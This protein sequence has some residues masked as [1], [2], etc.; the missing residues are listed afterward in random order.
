MA[1]TTDRKFVLVDVK[2][3]LVEQTVHCSREASVPRKGVTGA[4]RAAAAGTQRL[5]TELKWQNDRDTPFV[6]RG[7]SAGSARGRNASI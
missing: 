7:G 1:L 3:T 2:V 5:P 6:R 4:T